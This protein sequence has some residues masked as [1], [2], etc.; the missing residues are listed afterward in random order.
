MTKNCY[1]CNPS[2]DDEVIN[3]CGHHQFIAKGKFNTKC[4]CIYKRYFTDEQ[5]M[6]TVERYV[7]LLRR[8]GWKIFISDDKHGLPNVEIYAPHQ[9]T[10]D[11]GHELDHAQELACEYKLF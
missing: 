8:V 9:D 10:E 2:R 7:P 4:E 1:D 11:D 5:F 3:I 6:R